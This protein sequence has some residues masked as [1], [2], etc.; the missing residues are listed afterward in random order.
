MIVMQ[1]NRAGHFVPSLGLALFCASFL[2][3][4]TPTPEP[5]ET[6]SNAPQV[7]DDFTVRHTV[8][9]RRI[10]DYPP[11]RE[12]DLLWETR[13]WR[14][15]DTREK[16]NQTFVAW[17]SPLFKIMADEIYAGNLTAYS[18]ESDK[19]TKPLSVNDVRSMLTRTDTIMGYDVEDY[20]ETG[21]QVVTTEMN[22]E[23][24]KRFRIKEAWFFDTRTSTMQVRILG[25]APLISVRDSEGNFK[26]EKP[27][28]W[29]HYP[30]ARPVL[31]H[32]KVVSHSGNL[33]NTTTWEDLLER[34]QFA[35]YIMKESNLHD[36]RIED[37]ATGRDALLES[38]R[39][40]KDLLAKEHDLWSW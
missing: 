20:T 9:E 4:Q 17:E 26:F 33:A 36:R 3:A 2:C 5:V 38:E 12:A 14:V 30:S 24:V 1:S 19:F 8:A 10:L 35:S 31:A 15:V 16:I 34:R 11:V 27:L 22:W 40:G 6:N 21:L 37:Y 29:I 18:V 7:L 32:H 28:F 25:I 39:V 13:I 23:D